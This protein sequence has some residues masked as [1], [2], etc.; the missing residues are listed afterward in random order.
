MK[1]QIP[2]HNSIGEKIRAARKDKGLTLGELAKGI[3]SLGKMSNIE[4]GHIPVTDT[5][6]RKFAE[7]LNIPINQFADPNI[8]SKLKEL[9]LMK[10]KIR[11]LI[12][13]KHWSYAKK[14]LS[15]FK[16][17]MESYKIQSREIDYYFLNGEFYLKTNQ[18]E[19][20]KEFFTKVIEV[21]KNNNYFLRLKLKSYNALSSIYF[22][23]KK[24]ST[25]MQLLDKALQLSNESPTITKEE[26]NHIYYNRSILY[27][28][29]GENPLSLHNINK[30]S[31]DLISPF[32][33]EYI[34]LLISF[35]EDSSMDNKSDELLELREKSPQPYDKEGILRWWALTFYTMMATDS[36]TD[37]IEQLKEL[38]LSE[39]TIFDE[40][41]EF[42]QKRL[43][44]LQLG[45]FV[46]LTYS[47]PQS[48]I[49]E[50]I[51]RTKHQL[52]HIDEELLLARNYYLEGRYHQ[53]YQDDDTSSLI[54]YK[55]AL[56]SLSSN[57]EGFLKADILLEISRLKK[58]DNEAMD[59]LQLYHGHLKDHWLFTYFHELVLPPFKY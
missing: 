52:E 47:V 55:K 13:L 9:D 28:Y 35:L 33:T 25:C 45:I 21:E 17:K 14:E 27:L 39:F 8:N 54:L 5:E 44:L 6:L 7:K 57:Y 22:Q 58:I 26:R 34:K 46:C 48:I 30:V 15:D 10:Q 11:D 2:R 32:E 18:F 29:V 24:S 51:N 20:S 49:G 56:E 3:C 40:M 36:Q 37:F 12:F 59:A 31:H 41:K 16:A 23:Q 43:S 42:H 38:F 4:N 53:Q 19:R 50:L 1:K